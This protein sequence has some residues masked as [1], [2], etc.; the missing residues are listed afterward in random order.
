MFSSRM[1]QYLGFWYEGYRSNAIFEIGS[2]CVNATYTANP[3][4]TVG[5]WNQ[6]VN[7]LGDYTSIR[8]IAKVKD[9]SEPAAFIVTFDNPS[10]T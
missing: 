2:K 8:G 5:V 1:S 10:R 6:D 4:G 3:D 9:P 7:L